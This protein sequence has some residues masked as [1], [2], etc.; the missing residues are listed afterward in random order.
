MFTNHKAYVTYTMAQKQYAA[1]GCKQYA[2]GDW[3]DAR[4]RND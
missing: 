4:L 3:M 2:A 1:S